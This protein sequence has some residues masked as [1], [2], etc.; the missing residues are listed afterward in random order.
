MS[1][2]TI[3]KIRN[4]FERGESSVHQQ[5]FSS[6]NINW[7]KV[8]WKHQFPSYLYLK[9]YHY[10]DR[11]M[12]IYEANDEW[13]YVILKTKCSGPNVRDPTRSYYKCDQ[14]DGLKELIK[15]FGV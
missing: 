4:T 6:H 1:E 5:S 8:T 13:F 3:F 9:H 15:R 2:S 11:E 10:E 7:V 14:L 12:N